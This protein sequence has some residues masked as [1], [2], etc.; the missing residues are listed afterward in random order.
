MLRRR[1]AALFLLT[2]AGLAVYF[3]YP[4]LASGDRL[5]ISDWDALLFQHAA[6]MRSGFEYGQL[7]FWNPWYCGGNVLWQNP[8]T[9]LISPAYLLAPFVSM[10][11]AMKISVTLHYLAGFAGMHLLVTRVMRLTW[12]PAVVFIASLFVLAGGPA[13]HLVVGHATFL[14]YF[15]LPVFLFLLIR[16]IESTD[17]RMAFGAGAVLALS[18]YMGGLYVAFMAGLSAGCFALVAALSRRDWRP[19][20]AVA[21]IGVFAALLSAPK[22]VP[23]AA[24]LG[25]AQVV[26][27]R[28][29]HRPD[30]MT[31]DMVLQSFTD[32]Y[33]YPRKMMREQKYG[34]HEYGNY[35]GFLGAPLILGALLWIGTR[36]PRAELWLGISL[37]VT[38]VVLFGMMLGEAGPAAPYVWFTKLPLMEGFRLPS[39]YRLLLVLFGAALVAWVLRTAGERQTWTAEVRRMGAIV[40]VAATASL[41]FHNR[42]HFAGAF[43]LEPLRGGLAWMS[44]PAAPAI[45]ATTDG[46]TG[47]SPMLRAMF[48]GRA[49]LRCNEPLT[50][51]GTV[52]PSQPLLIAE[53]GVRISDVQFSPNRVRFGVVTTAEPG[54]VIFNSRHAAGW[55]S[56]AGELRLAAQGGLPYLE[57]PARSALRV[58]FSFMP[59]RLVTGLVLFLVGLM[60]GGATLWRARRRGGARSSPP[61]AAAPA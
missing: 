15:Y 4:L 43:P 52:R 7:P 44:Q 16:A 12:Y 24:Y 46:F 34:W 19:L 32:A 26:D 25:D 23:V 1:R 30:K 13:L 48:D 49:V 21:S 45:D 17:L 54:R 8:Q 61:P 51:R 50:F 6:V 22:L 40:L 31:A 27:S 14:P 33:Q 10:A 5:G 2:Y 39:R 41:A 56:D 9:P 53:G 20:V 35:L 60:L 18:I 37:A 36:R 28:T 3:T 59:P 38:C 29:F 57:V 47:D 42:A 58:Q 11:L 55:A